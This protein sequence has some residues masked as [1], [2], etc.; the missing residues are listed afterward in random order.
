M[1]RC[2]VCANLVDREEMLAKPYV[3]A[4]FRL[5]TAE[6]EPAKTF[7][8]SSVETPT[9]VASVAR[10]ATERTS[11]SSAE[12]GPKKCPSCLA[13]SAPSFASK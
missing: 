5:D 9:R 8:P 4:K 3:L 7:G 11:A 6:N 12:V 10:E 1:Q 2:E 13:V